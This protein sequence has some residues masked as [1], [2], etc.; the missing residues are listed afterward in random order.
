MPHQEALTVIA[1]IKPGQ[2]AAVKA[3]L[4]T[5]AEHGDSWDIIPFAKL[6]N[7]HFARFVVFDDSNDLDRNP[8][9]AQLALM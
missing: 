5:N 4:G 8:L 3:I 7:V 9:P 6:A 1:R 2:V